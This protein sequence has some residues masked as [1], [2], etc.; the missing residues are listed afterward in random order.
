MQMQVAYP[1][2]V[3]GLGGGKDESRAP[4]VRG[5]QGLQSPRFH[6]HWQHSEG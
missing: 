1:Q 2:R 3:L 6:R 4:A 5:R